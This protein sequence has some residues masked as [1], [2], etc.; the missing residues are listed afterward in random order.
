[1]AEKTWDSASEG[2]VVDE[3]TGIAFLIAVAETRT[4]ED[5]AANGHEEAKAV[6]DLEEEL[7][8]AK[9]DRPVEV[10]AIIAPDDEKAVQIDEPIVLPVERALQHSAT[11]ETSAAGNPKQ[12]NLPVLARILQNPNRPS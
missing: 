8:V 7:V 5:G 12:E 10:P 6:D 1:M 2:A 9:I 4:I 3:K 11:G